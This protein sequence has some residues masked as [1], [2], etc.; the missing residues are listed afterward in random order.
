MPTVLTAI[1]ADAED[2]GRPIWEIDDPTRLRR[3]LM[4]TSDG[5]HDQE[6]L[7][8]EIRGDALDLSNWKLTGVSWDAQE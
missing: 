4:T 1:G 5:S 2:C 3:Y 7:E 8:Y 6:I